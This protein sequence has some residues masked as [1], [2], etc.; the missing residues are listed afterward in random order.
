M[1]RL[2]AEA[3]RDDST[4]ALKNCRFLSRDAYH[5]VSVSDGLDFIYVIDLYRRVEARV[6]VV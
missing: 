2:S 6:E 4:R 3:S 1:A 5:H